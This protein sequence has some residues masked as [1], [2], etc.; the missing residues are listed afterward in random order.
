LVE[1]RCIAMGI[2][3]STCCCIQKAT[4][5]AITYPKS[6]GKLMESISIKLF[7]DTASASRRLGTSQAKD[8]FAVLNC[9]SA[10]EAFPIS[11]VASTSKEP[12]SY[13]P[14]IIIILSISSNHK[15]TNT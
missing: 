12:L 3:N 2:T 6:L 9:V 14:F 13:P 7:C 11:T 4:M 1:D 15:D 5:T 10:K 8:P